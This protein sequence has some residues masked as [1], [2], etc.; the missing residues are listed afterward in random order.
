MLECPQN[1]ASDAQRACR[2]CCMCTPHQPGPASSSTGLP[3]PHMSH[4]DAAG[5]FSNVQAPHAHG[6]GAEEDEDEDEDEAPGR[7]ETAPARLPVPGPAPGPGEPAS[8]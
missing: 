1:S 7:G 8:T 2:Q 4:L 5:A 6:E 3:V